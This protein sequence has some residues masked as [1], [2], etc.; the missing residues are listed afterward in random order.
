[1][2]NKNEL[3]IVTIWNILPVVPA[4]LMS[5][6]CGTLKLNINKFILG[7][8]IG[9]GIYF[10]IFIWFGNYLATQDTPTLKR[11]LTLS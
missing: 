9:Q 2:M 1:M 5:Y 10:A 6:V 7:T 11:G 3:S 4:D 8:L